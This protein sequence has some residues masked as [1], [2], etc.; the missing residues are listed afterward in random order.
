MLYTL[1][2]HNYCGIYWNR[3]MRTSVFR[4]IHVR[5]LVMDPLQFPCHFHITPQY[6]VQVR[7]LAAIL[8]Y[9]GIGKCTSKRYLAFLSC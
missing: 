5:T 8:E 1:K 4:H 3:T 7:K 2:W 6:F 9:M